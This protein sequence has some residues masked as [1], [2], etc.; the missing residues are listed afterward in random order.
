MNSTDRPNETPNDTD[1]CW[2]T[3][4][5]W[6]RDEPRCPE[7][8]R[9]VHCRNCEIFQEAGRGMLA[10]EPG[11]AYGADWATALAELPS[12]ASGPIEP[13]IIFRAGDELL[14]LP[15]A[16]VSEVHEWRSIR[17]VPHRRN[18]VLLGIVNVRGEIE[19][20]VAL[21]VLFGGRPRDVSMVPPGGRMI[22][23]GAGRTEWILAVDE[24]LGLSDVAL[25]A[26]ETVPATLYKSDGV[27]VRGLFEHSGQRVGIIDAELLLATLRQRVS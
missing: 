27:F 26:L 19:L 13:A 25:D 1:P 12:A 15:L 18:D 20:C 10:R 11:D 14:A 22:A 2:R 8:P 21:E 5:V 24:T 17:R 16:T 6:G 9:V 7:L 4:G 3:I 23:I